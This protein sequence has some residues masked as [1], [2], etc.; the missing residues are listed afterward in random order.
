MTSWRLKSPSKLSIIGP[1]VGIRWIPLTKG[2][3]N[4]KRFQ[5]MI[6]S[7]WRGQHLIWLVI[8]TVCSMVVIST[9]NKGNIEVPHALLS[10]VKPANSPDIEPLVWNDISWD[11]LEWHHECPRS[12]ENIYITASK[13]FSCW[14]PLKTTLSLLMIK[15]VCLVLEAPH[16]SRHL[17]S[18]FESHNNATMTHA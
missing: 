7:W 16:I 12:D 10:A 18:H 9:K 11:L 15:D 6:S 3:Y 1:F 5:A 2:Q 4:R 14:F 13:Y 17:V 8:S